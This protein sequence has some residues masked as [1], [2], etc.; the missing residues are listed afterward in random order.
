MITTSILFLPVWERLHPYLVIDIYDKDGGHVDPRIRIGFDN[1]PEAFGRELSFLEMPCVSCG[2]PNHPLRR[3][4]GDDWTRLFYAPT[5][6]LAVRLA[7]SRTR[8]AELEYERFKSVSPARPDSQ[9]TL[10]L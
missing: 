4:E 9:L 6:A 5:C 3:R 2:R 7:C 8:A 1:L 10:A